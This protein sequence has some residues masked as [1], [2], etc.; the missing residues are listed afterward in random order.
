MSK[1]KRL[2]DAELEIMNALWDADAPLTAAERAALAAAL[3]RALGHPF[4]V[5]IEAVP[6]LGRGPAGKLEEFVSHVAPR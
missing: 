1:I 2:P 3:H 5:T 6:T 4:A